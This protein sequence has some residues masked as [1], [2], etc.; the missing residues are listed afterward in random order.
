MKKIL[1]TL[2]FIV[3]TVPFLANAHTGDSTAS[4]E[5]GFMMMQQ[6][7]DG[8]LGD[9]LHEEMEGL[10]TKMMAGN[11]SQ[12]EMGRIVELMDQYPGVGSMMM[13]RMTGMDT[14]E[15]KFNSS[16]KNSMMGLYGIGG[17]GGGLFMI[18]FWILLIISIVALVKYTISG[19]KS[20][21]S[22]NASDIL[23]ERYA[24]GEIDK[25]EFEAKKKD[26]Q[27]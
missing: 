16:N 6:I 7:E 5:S 8:V 4:Q 23:K 9:E 27:N 26:L 2:F 10:M 13:G 24:S 19:R 21:S 22:K 3:V 14:F 25:N 12:I 17:F 18:L 20:D 11:L 1:L 15:S